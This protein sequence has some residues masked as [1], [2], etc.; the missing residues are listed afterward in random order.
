MNIAQIKNILEGGPSQEV[1]QLLD[2][3]EREGVRKLLASYYKRLQAE[4]AEKARLLNMNKYENQLYKEGF[5]LLAG[6]DEAGRG[7]LAGP[8]VVAA[9]ILPQNNFLP[10]L[11]D[12]KKLS[13][14]KREN[15]FEQIKEQALCF[16]IQVIPVDVIDTLNIYEATATGMRTSLL[17][18]KQTPDAALIDAMPLKNLPFHTISLV[19]G[20]SLSV[21]IAAASILA[22]VTRDRIMLELDEKYPRYGFARHKGYGTKE[23]IDAIREYGA[24]DEHRKTFEPIKTLLTGV[25]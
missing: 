11:N 15:L 19:S 9:A 7:P 10:G 21:S 2:G 25:K 13:A 20:D 1:L 6:V 8:L 22:K 14:A 17:S 3:D 23:H 4:A 18:L 5:K 24:I 12:S 16:D